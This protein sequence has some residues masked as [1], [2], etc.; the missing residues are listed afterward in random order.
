MLH[1]LF[2]LVLV[3]FSGFFLFIT[4]IPIIFGIDPPSYLKVIIL[5]NN[6]GVTAVEPSEF[7]VY[8]FGGTPG[9][10]CPNSEQKISLV[11]AG[12]L[13]LSMRAQYQDIPVISDFSGDCVAKS[14]S[15]GE[16]KINP[17]DK[18]TCVIDVN[19]AEPF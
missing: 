18:K 15:S 11:P 12:S 1:G 5:I 10:I 8:G 3:S 6:T 14:Y 16:V 17:G 4:E 9:E 7:C 19:F 2:I 13:T